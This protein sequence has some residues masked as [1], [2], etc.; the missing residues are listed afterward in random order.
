MGQVTPTLC[1]T[2]NVCKNT[3]AQQHEKSTGS[4][5]GENGKASTNHDMQLPAGRQFLGNSWEL[6]ED[7]PATLF[8]S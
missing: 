5:D 2:S 8:K 1:Y 7:S 3:D 6:A 4:R